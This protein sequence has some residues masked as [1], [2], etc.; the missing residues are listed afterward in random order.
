MDVVVASSTARNAGGVRSNI[1]DDKDT[2]NI[3]PPIAS[4]NWGM[5][6]NH[7]IKLN[8]RFDSRYFIVWKIV[9]GFGAL[10]EPNCRPCSRVLVLLPL[11]SAPF[12]EFLATTAIFL[13]P[14]DYFPTIIIALNELRF[15]CVRKEVELPNYRTRLQSQV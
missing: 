3:Y 12:S 4:A 15:L 10:A 5:A 2:R 14:G 1:E 7:E 8:I 13:P 9:D 6:E 11:L